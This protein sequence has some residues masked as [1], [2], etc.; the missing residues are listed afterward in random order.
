[1]DDTLHTGARLLARWLALEVATANH[2]EIATGLEENNLS[3]RLG[4]PVLDAYEKYRNSLPEALVNQTS[5]FK[6]AFNEI[7]AGGEKVF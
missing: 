5:Y 2:E 4:V 3:A 6:D 1:V 7:L